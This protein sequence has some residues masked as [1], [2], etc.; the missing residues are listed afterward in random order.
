M[1][2]NGNWVDLVILFILAFFAYEAFSVGLGVILADL[3]SFVLSLVIALRGYP[4]VSKLFQTNF[5]LNNNVSNALGFLI[6][7]VVTE[8]V[9][10]YV[11][12]RIIS[13]ISIKKYLTNWTK[14]LAIIPSIIEGLI[15]IA[16]VLTV[17]VA[18]PI[19]PK[20]KTDISGSKI[21]SF[22]VYQTS[23]I[24]GKL[25]DIFGGVIEQSL[26]YF[27]IKPES[28]ES[29]SLNIEDL[30]LSVD[31]EAETQMFSL[32]NQEREKQGIA[33]LSWDPDI[34]PVARAHA[35]DMWKRKYF[36]HYSPEGKD[37]GDRLQ[38]A[39][40]N[41]TLAG[42]NLALAPTLQTAHQ[43]LMNSPGHRANILETRFKKMGIGVIDNGY[44]GKM[45]V[46]VFTD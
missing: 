36:S 35:E 37:V 32:V 43:G 17:L 10:G 26:T 3:F 44:Y 12:I 24:E 18:L 27:T 20:I 6:L 14:I 1:N 41:Y 5:S 23:G 2:L 13:K 22:L 40:I 33:L 46:Q 29:V 28:N 11:F 21:G 39:H 8:V 25:N 42:E 9:V 30:N 15:L 34:V 45:F 7:A 19:S 38:A 16:F 31:S 4:L